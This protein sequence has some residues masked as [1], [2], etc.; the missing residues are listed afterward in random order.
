MVQFGAESGA[1]RAHTC[2]IKRAKSGTISLKEEEEE[3]NLTA[4]LFLANVTKP[5][6]TFW[7]VMFNKKFST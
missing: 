5:L 2:P 3:A 1:R 7:S 4:S 6:D